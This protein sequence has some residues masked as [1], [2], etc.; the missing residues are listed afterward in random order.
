[1]TSIT[2]LIAQKEA[3]EQQIQHLRKNERNGAIAKAREIIA[4]FELVA[5]DLFPNNQKAAKRT[6]GK[7]APKYRDQTTGKTWT[8]RGKPPSWIVGQNR[9]DY[10]I[11]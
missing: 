6:R 8:G 10:L 3:I 4:E 1:M 5:E 11:K 9:D 2:E 7:A